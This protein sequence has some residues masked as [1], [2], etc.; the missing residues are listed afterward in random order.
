MCSRKCVIKP[1][2]YLFLFFYQVYCLVNG[3]AGTI[4]DIIFNLPIMK[5]N[6]DHVLLKT[7]GVVAFQ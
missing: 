1:T 7:K 4:D 3:D 2:R 5:E 6:G